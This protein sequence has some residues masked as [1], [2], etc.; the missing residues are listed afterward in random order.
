LAAFTREAARLLP[1]SFPIV[2]IGVRSAAGQEGKPDTRQVFSNH[3][4]IGCDVHPG[5]R[6]HS[7]FVTR[8]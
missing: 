3:D 2:E 8:A 5:L 7:A 1:V 4:D 6:V